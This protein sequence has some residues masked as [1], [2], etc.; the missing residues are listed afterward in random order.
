MKAEFLTEA[1]CMR[2]DK[3]LIA[4]GDAF[5]LHVVAS[6]GITDDDAFMTRVDVL[7]SAGQ[8]MFPKLAH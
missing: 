3:L 8:L 2:Y 1:A 5:G 4:S 6:V 7:A